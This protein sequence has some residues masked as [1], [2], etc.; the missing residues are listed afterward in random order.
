MK[1]DTLKQGI[2]L[3]ENY[4]RVSGFDTRLYL[5]KKRKSDGKISLK[6]C[7]CNK[8]V[9]EKHQDFMQTAKRKDQ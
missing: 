9:L 4:A 6:Y 1:F 3:Y 5:T 2:S 7:V 8:G